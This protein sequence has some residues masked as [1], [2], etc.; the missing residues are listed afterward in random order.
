MTHAVP[1]TADHGLEIGPV[2]TVA[3]TPARVPGSVRRTTSIDMSRPDGPS[4]MVVAD[5]RGR[6]IRTDTAGR[7]EV[8]EEL[9]IRIEIE[10]MTG[11]VRAID[12]ASLEEL[13]GANARSGFGR[14][15]TALLPA[16]AGQRTLRYTTLDDLNGGVLVG[17]YPMLYDDLFPRS[18]E[19]VELMAASQADVCAGWAEGGPLIEDM[20]ERQTSA[21]PIGPRAPTIDGDDPDGWH[22]MAPR[23]VGTVR[24]RRRLDVVE[25][26]SGALL[27][28]THFRDTH[29]APDGENV[30]HEYLVEAEID[31][32]VIA[33]VDVQARVL[34]WAECPGAVAS[35]QG[36]VG[37][38][39]EELPARVRRE[40]VGPTT[41]THLNSTMR[42]LADVQA[43]AS[44]LGGA[45][46]G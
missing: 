35:A 46:V 21:L 39:I 45:S 38:R 15:V 10:P 32:G 26:V 19:V 37:V 24:R 4:G 44:Y 13:I 33:R 27:V 16:E 34:P 43:L 18:P 29:T 22:V 8:L 14:R 25:S 17:G 11:L 5:V 31:A 42:S 9:A 7:V 36:V 23:E 40:L 1:R 28:D 12:D 30:M 6:D 20:R 41:C 3:G 2:D